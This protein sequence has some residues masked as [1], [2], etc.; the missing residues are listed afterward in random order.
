M[1]TLRAARD[2]HIY[3]LDF[4]ATRSGDKRRFIA[5]YTPG[6]I[7]FSGYRDGGTKMETEKRKGEKRHVGEI[8]QRFFIVFV[9]HLIHEHSSIP[10][11]KQS[12]LLPHTHTYIY[13]HTIPVN[14]IQ[15]NLSRVRRSQTRTSTTTTT[16]INETTAGSLRPGLKNDSFV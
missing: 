10:P 2:T 14:F 4:F 12:T 11:T 5:A 15:E 9:A 6:L 7:G 1:F 8:I 13:T 3:Q 16:M